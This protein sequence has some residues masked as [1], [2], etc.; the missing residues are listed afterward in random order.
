MDEAKSKNAVELPEK[1]TLQ[2]RHE[3]KSII[4]KG[5]TEIPPPPERRPGQRGRI[6]RGKE[7]NLLERFDVR[8]AE[9]IDYIENFD[10]PFD[11]NQAERD[12]RMIKVKQKISGTFRSTEMAQNFC[13]IRSYISTAIKQGVNVFD[14]IAGAF[15]G[16]YFVCQ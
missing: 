12:I 10:R 15:T 6:A 3:Y 5:E 13:T 1:I 11:N 7:R 16:K 4:D 14:A 8:Q 2:L 9:I